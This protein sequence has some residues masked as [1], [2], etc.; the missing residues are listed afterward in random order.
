M[1]L[2]N[3]VHSSNIEFQHVGNCI[4]NDDCAEV[5][6]QMGYIENVKTAHTMTKHR[7]PL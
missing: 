5:R 7:A 6:E 3:T 1:A 2:E 4:T